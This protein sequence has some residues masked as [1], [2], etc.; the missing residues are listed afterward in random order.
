MEIFK[1][2]EVGAEGTVELVVV[3]LVLHHAGAREQVEVVYAAVDHP[4]FE[5]G[6]QVHQFADG[7]RHLVAAQ[8]KEKVD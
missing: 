3:L 8:R 7:R 5:R 2:L 1:A 4:A 6:D